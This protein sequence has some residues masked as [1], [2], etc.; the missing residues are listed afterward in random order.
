MTNEEPSVGE[1]SFV[2]QSP[3]TETTLHDEL[4]DGFKTTPSYDR[5]RILAAT[6][7]E[8]GV[9][10]VEEELI[11]FCERG[12]EIEIYIGLSMG[13]DPDGIRRLKR[14]QDQYPGLISLKLIKNGSAVNL[15]HPK[16]YW[17]CSN[18]EHRVILG[19]PNWS[20][21]GFES[22]VEAFSVVTEPV[23]EGQQSNFISDVRSAFDEVRRLNESSESWGS[24]HPPTESILEQLESTTRIRRE[25]EQTQVEITTE[26]SGEE[27]LWPLSRTTPE[28]VMELNKESRMSQI[29]PP[30]EIWRRFFGVDSDK[31]REDD[32]E[33]PSFDLRNAATGA[34]Y[35]RH[36]VT[37]DHQGTIEIPEAKDRD[38]PAV[39][40][41]FLVFRKTGIHSLDYQLFL[42]GEH[43]EADQIAEFL[44][45]NGYTPGRS[46]RLTF[47]SRPS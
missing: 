44:E 29:V 11:E 10:R 18:T 21:Q 1:L 27:G 43:S 15:F 46:S 35:N 41:A 24:L 22:N 12:G 7:S 25:E 9:L 42:E 19:S 38:D 36:V 14:L 13:P 31:F 3:S 17:F 6:V 2:F 30:N 47:I 16:I 8:R 39:Q 45:A 33:L 28:L 34:Q 26:S 40:R 4:E 5:L 37:H 23:V 32:P 20:S